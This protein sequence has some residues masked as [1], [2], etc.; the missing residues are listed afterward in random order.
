M[1]KRKKEKNIRMT[2]QKQRWLKNRNDVRN[3][4]IIKKRGSW[5]KCEKEKR[6]AG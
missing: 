6:E 4:G 1:Q 5:K 2:G 3:K